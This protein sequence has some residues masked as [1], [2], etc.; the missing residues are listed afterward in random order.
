M[1]PAEVFRLPQASFGLPEHSRVDNEQPF[2][3]ADGFGYVE[4]CLVARH[5]HAGLGGQ[6]RAGGASAIRCLAEGVGVA[7]RCYER[8][9]ADVVSA[10]RYEAGR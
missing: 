3:L 5:Q 1:G 9:G 6:L 8:C 4:Q 7:V 10:R 2:G